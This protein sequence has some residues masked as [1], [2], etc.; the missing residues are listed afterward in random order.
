[1][2]LVVEEIA[3]PHVWKANYNAQGTCYISAK[4]HMTWLKERLLRLF[5]VLIYVENYSEIEML[6]DSSAPLLD[7]S[8]E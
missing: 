8:V 5:K 7:F 6:S 4:F 2:T 3:F 1:M